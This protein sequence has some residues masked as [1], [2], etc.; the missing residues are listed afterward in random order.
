MVWLKCVLTGI[1]TVLFSTLL[2]GLGVLVWQALP[3]ISSQAA[4]SGGIGAVSIGFS[5]A[6][7][8]LFVAVSFGLG[9]V[10]RYRRLKG[11]VSPR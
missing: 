4:G 10:W 6:S 7:L 5:S 1:L 9:F 3:F 2:L 8:L 11:L